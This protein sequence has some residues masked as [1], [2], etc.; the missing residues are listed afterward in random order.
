M[1]TRG[2][3]KSIYGSR[4]KVLVSPSAA[5]A[6]N[7][8]ICVPGC[9]DIRDSFLAL[10]DLIYTIEQSIPVHFSVD[11]VISE[12]V[13]PISARGYVSPPV[14][15][16]L[17]WRQENPNVRFNS[18]D[19]IHRLQIK[20][21]YIRLGYNYTKDRMFQDTIGLAL[22]SYEYIDGQYIPR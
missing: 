7:G 22:V 21:I 5:A 18:D 14:F 15:V 9:P 11:G 2:Y 12:F 3:F 20:D 17:I 16:R 1:S 19:S 6:A 8:G 4:K 10:N 13:A